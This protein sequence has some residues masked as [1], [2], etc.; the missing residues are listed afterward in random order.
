MDILSS[1]TQFASYCSRT[2][3]FFGVKSFQRAEREQLPQTSIYFSSERF[4]SRLEVFFNLSRVPHK[5]LPL[6]ML[7]G[8]LSSYCRVSLCL[9][10]IFHSVFLSV[11]E[12]ET[13]LLSSAAVR[14]IFDLETFSR[15]FVH[16][17]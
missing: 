14:S 12:W 5:T 16:S 10:L 9:R 8:R 11:M 4:P 7:Q 6:L 15:C 2:H 1:L 13:G 17:D 3:S